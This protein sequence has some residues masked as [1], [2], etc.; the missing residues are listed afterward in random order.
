MTLVP[1]EPDTTTPSGLF[2]V[3]SG[4]GTHCTHPVVCGGT[5]YLRLHEHARR[6]TCRGE[7]TTLGGGKRSHPH[8]SMAPR[9]ET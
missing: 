4:A 1:V 8:S 3:S 2:S 7:I 6:L 9:C 5:L